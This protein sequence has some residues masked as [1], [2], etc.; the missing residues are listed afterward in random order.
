MQSV[1]TAKERHIQTV[2]FIRA[3]RSVDILQIT[4]YLEA[5]ID[6]CMMVPDNIFY[7][8]LSAFGE[9]CALANPFIIHLML[10]A[11]A[12][13]NLYE[14]RTL[15]IGEVNSSTP[16]I[17]VV[18]S[19]DRQNLTEHTDYNITQCVKILLDGGADITLDINKPAYR[20]SKLRELT[21][22]KLL[23]NPNIRQ[24]SYT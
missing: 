21:A 17:L 10:K 13:P 14:K 12:D 23:P 15:K 8:L 3:V 19:Y 2:N 4:E 6:P 20:I 18:S 11:G 7:R 16:L 24:L 5:G 9:A 22:H 1:P